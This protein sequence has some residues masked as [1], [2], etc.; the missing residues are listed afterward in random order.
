M[1]FFPKLN[2]L[3]RVPFIAHLSLVAFLALVGC[4]SGGTS[5]TGSASYTLPADGAIY[6]VGDTPIFT[7][8]LGIDGASDIL[9]RFY[10]AME[11]DDM[12]VDVAESD[13][14]APDE[15]GVATW[16]PEI[17][18]LENRPY[19]WRWEATYLEN[20][21]SGAD[22]L[23]E[24]IFYVL[25]ANG[26]KA[27]SPRDGGY[28]DENL[29]TASHLTV[30]NAYTFSGVDVV[31]YDF[32][33]FDD[34]DL[35]Q[36]G[37]V[38]DGVA[39][40]ND[41][42]RTTWNYIPAI[43]NS[44]KHYWRAR[45][46]IDGN[47]SQWMGPYSFTTQNLCLAYGDVYAE[48]AVEWIEYSPCDQLVMTDPEEALGPPVVGGFITQDEPGYGFI[49]M[50]H[51]SE[52]IVEMGRVVVDGPGEDIGVYEYVSTEP[53]ELFAGQS[54]IG[55]WY[56]MG[57]IWCHVRCD[58]DLA[59]AGLNYAKYFKIR[60]MPGRCYQTAGPDIYGLEVFNITDD[61]NECF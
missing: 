34:I 4:D 9:F 47:L 11:D 49:S 28:F 53:L 18:L 26:L 1:L 27:I 56:S 42:A 20:G 2:K 61:P 45:V 35:T 50:G 32:E 36:Q 58:F 39:Q 51:N 31:E 12:T 57:V 5:E 8:T 44:G 16:A 13:Q 22:D 40:D 19:H 33:V 46:V 37:A 24:R 29:T 43:Q 59:V 6:S 7:A 30:A 60:S 23:P 15:N 14:I 21:E 48:Y 17:A 10:L 41:S 55:P 38:K 25:L 52:L 3:V 54:E